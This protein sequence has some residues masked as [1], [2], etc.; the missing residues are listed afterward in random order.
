MPGPARAGVA[1]SAVSPG[2][3]ADR[4]GQSIGR[5]RRHDQMQVVGHEAIGPHHHTGL[6]AALGQDI[7]AAGVVAVREEHG[8]PPIAPL[9]DMMKRAGNDDAAEAGHE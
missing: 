2:R 3:F 9:R 4:S 7:A 6:A 1:E 8:L 5:L